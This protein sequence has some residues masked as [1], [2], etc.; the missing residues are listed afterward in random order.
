MD[1]VLNIRSE[2]EEDWGAVREVL[3]SAFPTAEEADL[4]ERLRENGNLHLSLVAEIDGDIVGHVAFSP[5]TIADNDQWL[6][7]GL[8]P[9]AVRPDRQR[10]GIGS[11]LTRDGLARCRKTGIPYVVLIG[12]PDYYPRFGFRPGADYHLSDEYGAGEAFM[13]LELRDGWLAGK[14]G[15]V[16]YGPEFAAFSD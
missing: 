10:A 8:A 3:V 13:A 6:G 5:V 15:T 11:E 16:K 2:R 12:H 1:S 14:A 9:L 4:V 7:A